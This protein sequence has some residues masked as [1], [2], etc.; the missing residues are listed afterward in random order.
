[1]TREIKVILVLK[2]IQELQVAKVILEIGGLKEM[3]VLVVMKKQ[4]GNCQ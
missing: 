3:L 1:M 4:D 2:V